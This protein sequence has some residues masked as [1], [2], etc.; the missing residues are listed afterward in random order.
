[1]S[2]LT[3]GS[4]ENGGFYPWLEAG[5]GYLWV[6]DSSIRMSCPKLIKLAN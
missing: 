6:L 4:L 1:M 3:L 5:L 2:D